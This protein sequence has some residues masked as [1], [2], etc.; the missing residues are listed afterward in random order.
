[1]AAANPGPHERAH[2]DAPSRGV[3]RFR[4]ALLLS[5]ASVLALIACER[6]DPIQD[7]TLAELVARQQAYE[8]RVVRTRGTVRTF[9]SPRH[10]WLED[11]HINRVG[12]VPQDLIAP[13]LGREL[14]VVGR[15]AFVQGRGRQ[16][17]ISNIEPFDDVR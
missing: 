17:T 10:Y 14:T 1:M 4:G 15:F 16:I 3:A 9:P 8:G 13:H 2:R 7:V 5:A 12:L 11:E 6:A